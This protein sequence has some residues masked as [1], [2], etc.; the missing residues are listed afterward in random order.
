MFIDLLV[1]EERSSIDY[2]FKLALFIDIYA[3]SAIMAG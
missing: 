1:G 3:P 2:S